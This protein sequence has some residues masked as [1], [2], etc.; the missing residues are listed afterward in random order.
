MAASRA[1]WMEKPSP[2]VRAAKMLAIAIIVTLML[3]PFAYVIL[4]SVTPPGRRCASG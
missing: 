1:P 3:Y 4:A 2:L